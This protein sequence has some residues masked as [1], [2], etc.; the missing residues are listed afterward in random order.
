MELA[1]Q[2][3]QLTL[4]TAEASVEADRVKILNTIAE[5]AN[6]D[7]KPP[8]THER[9]DALN[10]ILRGRFA[11]VALRGLLAAGET[12]E[13]AAKL[14]K[15]SGRR[16][17]ELGFDGVEAFDANAMQLIAQNLPPELEELDMAGGGLTKS[18][19]QPL[20]D[21]LRVHASVTEVR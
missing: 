12:I 13:L 8:K 17:L 15:G 1:K 6:L 7:A 9:Y 5:Q 11:I 18:H 4:E 21:A 20:A 2:A 19:M 3:F 16:T 10:A 14:L